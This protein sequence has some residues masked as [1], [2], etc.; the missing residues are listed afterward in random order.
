MSSAIRSRAGDHQRQGLVGSGG[1]EGN[2]QILARR[3]IFP[4]IGVGAQR[5]AGCRRIP[6]IGIGVQ[7]SSVFSAAYLWSPS[8]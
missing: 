3:E 2:E 4:V 6:I 8:S 7:A 1:D 5:A